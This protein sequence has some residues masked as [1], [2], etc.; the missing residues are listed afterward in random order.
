MIVENDL[1]KLAEEVAKSAGDFVLKQWDRPFKIYKK[2]ERDIYTQVDI[3]SQ[4]K[5]VEKIHNKFSDHGFL[6][7]E[8]GLNFQTNR[9]ITWIIDPIDGSINYSK[10]RPLF[11]ISIAVA[12]ETSV[13]VGVTFDPCRNEMFS[14][15]RG[16]GFRINGEKMT[17]NWEDR[18]EKSAIAFDWGH[19]DK[20][21]EF[22]RLAL[23]KIN[24]RVF[25]IFTLGSASLALAW[26]AA[27][28]LDGYFSYHL[29]SWD[30]A[31][32]YLMI[33]EAGGHV[34]DCEGKQWNWRSNKNGCLAGGTLLRQKLER[35]II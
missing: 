12:I 14:A 3:D 6:A 17:I 24:K 29:D 9:H 10:H 33:A 22:T 26:V 13:V 2:G 35:I 5:I 1:L 23:S 20:S 4:K 25:S 34:T 15:A 21:R 19:C 8:P 28:R 7:E 11:C 27:G 16:I 30:I 18:L 32:G 31:A